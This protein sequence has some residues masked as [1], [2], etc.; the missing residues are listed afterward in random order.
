MPA[1]RPKESKE[2]INSIAEI[3]QVGTKL[4][5]QGLSPYFHFS[6]MVVYVAVKSTPKSWANP[7]QPRRGFFG[8][9]LEPTTH[10]KWDTLFLGQ[11]LCLKPP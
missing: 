10:S 2:L 5:R 8:S 7:F 9:N 6:Y 11:D 4:F 1:S 3:S